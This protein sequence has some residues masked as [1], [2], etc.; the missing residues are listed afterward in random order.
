[1][2]TVHVALTVLTNGHFKV[3]VRMHLLQEFPMI[4]LFYLYMHGNVYGHAVTSFKSDVINSWS[5][6]A[7]WTESIIVSI[8]CFR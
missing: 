8:I 4:I 1:M 6:I 3:P 7:L 2:Y 5:N